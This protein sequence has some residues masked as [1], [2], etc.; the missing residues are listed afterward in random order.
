MRK[1]TRSMTGEG[2]RQPEEAI[3]SPVSIEDACRLHEPAVDLREQGQHAAAAACARYALAAFERECGPD[4]P[5]V[6][7]ILNNLAGICEDQGNYAEAARLAQ[8]AV[9][10]LE[11]VT[12]SPDLELL[13][14]ESLRTLAGVYRAQGRYAEA[15]PLSQRALALAEAT[16]GPDHLETA[17]CLNNLAVL[18]KYTA[19]FATAARLYRRAL[20]ITTRV[21]GPERPDVATL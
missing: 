18:Y 14:V 10:I 2:D 6:A 3:P 1:K 11:P 9:A 20:A 15:E 8:R 5:D 12:G 13:R 16:L 19:Q 17:T 21:L 7:N 4:H